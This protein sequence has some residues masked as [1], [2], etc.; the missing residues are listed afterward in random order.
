MTRSWVEIIEFYRSFRDSEIN[1]DFMLLFVEKISESE[2]ANGL[3]AWDAVGHVPSS[4]IV[5]TF[6]VKNELFR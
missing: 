4:N 2:Y 6:S 5:V 1:L 3:H